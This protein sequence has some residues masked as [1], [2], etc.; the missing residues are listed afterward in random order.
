MPTPNILGK[1]GLENLFLTTNLYFPFI[2]V[3]LSF[4]GTNKSHISP[5]QSAKSSPAS[6]LNRTSK[7]IVSE[8]PLGE[9]TVTS[10]GTFAN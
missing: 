5:V 4:I 3:V 2:K 9:T 10:I 6:S 8:E 1:N 7:L